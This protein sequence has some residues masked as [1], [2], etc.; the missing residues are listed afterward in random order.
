VGFLA[1]DDYMSIDAIEKYVIFCEENKGVIPIA[2]VNLFSDDEG[3][4]FSSVEKYCENCYK[5]A[6]LSQNEQYKSLLV[7]NMIVA[8]AAAFYPMEALKKLNGFDERFWI[9]DYPI[10]IK[11]LR[12][13]YRFGL[14][15]MPLIYYR[16][17]NKSITGSKQNIIKK[18]EVKFFFRLRFW[19]MLRAGMIREAVGQ[20][21][22]WIKIAMKK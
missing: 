3:C 7:K 22:S 5:F 15:D 21:R 2:K 16:I 6:G 13:G 10:N 17:S 1:A 12:N 18:T 4:N 8:P 19:Y 9:E 20:S 14:L 11:I